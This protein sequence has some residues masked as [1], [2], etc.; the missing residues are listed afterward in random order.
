MVKNLQ[1]SNVANLPTKFGVFKAIC[2]KQI[3]DNNLTKEH[4]VV[5]T[6]K[7]GKQPLV[8]VHSE[9]LTGD[10]FCS[11]KCDCG[12]ELHHSLK[13][14]NKSKQKD[15]G[16]IIYLRQ[17]GRD[18]GLFNKINAYHLQDEGHDTVEANLMLGFKEDE[19]DYEIIENI[20]DYFN[21]KEIE[22]ITNNPEK[23]ETISKFVKIK[24]KKILQGVNECNKKYLQVKKEKMGHLI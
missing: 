23:I 7:L 16:M 2:F 4:L 5:F 19:R 24:R 1:I 11:L 8:R 13:L 6:E 14:I 18:I 20:F 21:I 9:C 10:A 22:L 12:P 17:E 15:G 3:Y